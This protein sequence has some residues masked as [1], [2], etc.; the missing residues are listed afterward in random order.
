MKL[1]GIPVDKQHLCLAGSVLQYPAQPVESHT[2]VVAGLCF[3]ASWGRTY[4]EE[5]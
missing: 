2:Q 1:D 4:E 5:G 3:R